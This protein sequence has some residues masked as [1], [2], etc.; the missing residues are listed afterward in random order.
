MMNQRKNLIEGVDW[1]GGIYDYAGFASMGGDETKR[2]IEMD[3]G[4]L[5]H[6]NP[7]N[8]SFRECGD[9]FVRSFDHEVTIKRDLGDFAKRG[10]DR[11][12]D[13]KIWNEMAVHDVDVEN[14]GSARD[15][16]LRVFPEPC[17]V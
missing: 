1:G 14:G 17:E 6:G 13:C 7:S 12:T 8:A 16:G 10:D 5:M 2:A 15:G 11:R 4:F 9:E 3:T